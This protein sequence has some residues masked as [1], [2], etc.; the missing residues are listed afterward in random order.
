[1][2]IEAIAATDAFSS[3]VF[4]GNFLFTVLS[5]F[6]VDALCMAIRI[7]GKH[8]QWLVYIRVQV[9]VLVT[10]GQHY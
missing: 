1:L 9:L 6:Y 4:H 5:D 10:L 2:H 8:A 3:L 7:Q